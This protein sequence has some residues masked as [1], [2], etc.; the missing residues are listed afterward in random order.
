MARYIIR[1]LLGV[2]PLLFGITIITFLLVHAV[3]GSPIQDL[4]LN[5]DVTPA[6]RANIERALGI[7]KPLHEQYLIWIGDLVRGDLGISLKTYR[8]VST[9]ILERLPDTILLAA[10]SLLLALALAVPIGVAAAVRRNSIF[11]HITN[12]TATLANSLPTFWIG[13]LLILFFAVQFSDWGWPALPS[14]GVRTL[15]GGG[16]LPDRL[17]HLI[18]PMV[19]LAF[20]QTAAWLRF[21]RGQMLEVIQQDYV[22]T[23]RAKGLRERVVI[24]R[25]AFRNAMLPMITLVGLSIPDLFGGA[26]ITETIFAWPGIGQLTINASRD[27]DYTVVM[28]IV[29][30]IS[31]ITVLANLLSDILYSAVDPRVKYS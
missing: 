18:L 8:P 24:M 9:I 26:V 13:L 12:V 5:P 20:A 31:V 7:D 25:H 17:K 4:R 30:F 6:D 15:P 10:S 29:V 2:P 1:R 14:G 16:D 21:I 23:A 28:G 27:R 19:T 22:R 3:P 11:D